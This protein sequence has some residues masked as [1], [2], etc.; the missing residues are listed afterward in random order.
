M[1]EHP[2]PEEFA[3]YYAGYIQRVPVGSDIFAV[4][5]GQAEELQTLLKAYPDAQANEHPAPGEWSVKEVIGHLCDSE[6]VFAYRALRIAR[7]DGTPLAGFEQDDYVR[8]TD[9]N[10]RSLSSLIEEFALQR[11]ANVVCFGALTE[12]ELMRR[13]TA[14][15]N[16]VSVR[17][18]LFIMA[19]HVMHHVESLTTDYHVNG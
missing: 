10:A 2:Q 6:R 1:I 14:N 3:P 7:A 19:G 12:P 15:M 16:P 11:S 5:S 13:G 17:A 18:L 4:L 9:F 8:A